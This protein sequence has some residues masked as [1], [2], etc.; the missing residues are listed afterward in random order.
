MFQAS[1]QPG[2]STCQCSAEAGNFGK[3][4]D[5]QPGFTVAAGIT[6]QHSSQPKVPGVLLETSRHARL[7]PVGG[8]QPP[9]NP[10]ALYPA[11][12][13]RAISIIEVKRGLHSRYVYKVQQIADREAAAVYLQ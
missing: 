5:I 7:L 6:E 3:R 13:Q 9:T 2:Q 10:S 12:Q 11:L 4:F 1:Y 8:M